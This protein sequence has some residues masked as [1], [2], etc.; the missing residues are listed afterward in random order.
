ML[1]VQEGLA[2]PACRATEGHRARVSQRGRAFGEFR[3]RDVGL[4]RAAGRGL[5]GIALP[6]PG[7][8]P[9]N[10]A[11]MSAGSICQKCRKCSGIGSRKQWV[12]SGCAVELAWGRTPRRGRPARDIAVGE[13]WLGN[14]APVPGWQ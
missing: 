11:G 13:R 9:L 3:P 5:Q 4:M 10:C 12:C 7:R 2:R 1:Q 6:V 8:A 14:D